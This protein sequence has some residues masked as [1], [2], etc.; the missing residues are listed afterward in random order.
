VWE[1][2]AHPMDFTKCH[3]RS[4]KTRGGWEKGEG[5]EWREQE[6]GGE[7]MRLGE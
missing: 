7:G 3:C 2:R 4:N 1:V 5:E 6:T